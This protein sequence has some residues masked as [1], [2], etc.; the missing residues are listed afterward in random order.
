[1]EE[2]IA[3]AERTCGAM[4]EERAIRLVSGKITEAQERKFIT[5][6]LQGE[7]GRLPCSGDEKRRLMEAVLFGQGLE[8]TTEQL[9]EILQMIVVHRQGQERGHHAGY[10]HRR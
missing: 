3:Q 1:M 9:K 7:A 2:E 5:E 4:E 10:T 8:L 6:R